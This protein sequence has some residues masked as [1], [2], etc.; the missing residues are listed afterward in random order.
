MGPQTIREVW[1]FMYGKTSC[2]QR[3][4][5]TVLAVWRCSIRN[6]LWIG[7]HLLKGCARKRIVTS[8]TIR[9]FFFSTMAGILH[10]TLREVGVRHAGSFKKGTS[11]NLENNCLTSKRD[12]WEL[13]NW[14]CLA[15]K[16]LL[17]DPWFK[18]DLG[19]LL[20][21]G[22]RPHV[23]LMFTCPSYLSPGIPDAASAAT[24]NQL[25][26]TQPKSYCKD[27]LLPLTWSVRSATLDRARS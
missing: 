26:F 3:V 25:D 15:W 27:Q 9:F 13:V 5:V 14:R 2:T 1:L 20:Y 12:D 11:G 17:S 16:R 4:F 21:C 24:L 22:V 18:R 23:P 7:H 19:L 8:V 10:V 6:P